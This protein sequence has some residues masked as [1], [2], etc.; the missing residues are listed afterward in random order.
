MTGLW[1]V[2]GRNATTFD[3]RVHLDLEYIETMSFSTDLKL[4]GETVLVV[5]QGKGA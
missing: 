4:L 1:Q 3:E 5:F 2:R